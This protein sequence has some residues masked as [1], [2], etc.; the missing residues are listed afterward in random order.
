MRP[1]LLRPRYLVALALSAACL[2]AC[3]SDEE[4]FATHME[5]AEGYLAE[6]KTKE[7]LIEYRSALQIDPKNAEVNHRIADI[8]AD[9]G[10]VSEAAFFYRE[11]YRLDPE[12]VDAAMKEAQLLLFTD[13]ARTEQIIEEG[14]QR[15]PNVPIVHVARSQLALLKRDTE[16]ALTAI[17]TGIQLAPDEPGV[18]RQLGAVHQAR[19]RESRLVKKQE[20]DESVFRSAI[21]AFERADEL[22]GGNLGA[23]IERARVFASWS[24]H[25]E[26]AEQ[27]YRGVVELARSGGDDDVV[28]Y[29]ASVAGEYALR[30][31]NIPMRKW[32]LREM[33]SVD[34]SRIPNWAELA[35]LEDGEAVYAELLAKRPEDP[36]AHSYYASFLMGK[37]KNQEAITHLTQVIDA[38]HGTAALWEQ[39]LRIHLG[40]RNLPAARATYVQ[41]ADAHPDDPLTERAE[42]R[43][44]L[45]ERRRERAGQILR[46]LAGKSEAFETLRLLAFAEYANGN[47]PAAAAAI[48]RAI[49]LTDSF[50]TEAV[51]LKARIHHDAEDWILALRTLR[52][53]IGRNVVLTNNERLM[54]ARVLYETSRR[55]LGREVLELLLAEPDAP[56][57]A[58]VE[59]ARRE[60]KVRP[61]RAYQHLEKAWSRAPL[62]NDVLSELMALDIQLGKPIASLRRLNGA[63]RTGRANPKILLMRAELLARAGNYDQA[64]ADA[65]RAFE[66]APQ[67]R[68]AVDL[69]LAIYTAQGRI[70]EARRSFEEAEEAGVLHAGARLLLGRLY[71]SAGD[72]QNAERMFEKV[73]DEQPGHAGAKNDLAFLLAEEGRDL[74]RALRLAQEAQ[75]DLGSNASAADTV[76]YVFYHKGL[77]EAALQQFRYAIEL[78]QKTREGNLP[79]Y[80]YHAG[81]TLRALG[82][83]NEA[84][85]AFEKALEIDGDF[86]N[87][88]DARQQLEAARAAGPSSP[89]PS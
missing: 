47:L 6:D 30:V 52:L 11:A 10:G 67:L 83:E 82:R 23:R 37:G 1:T 45:A 84:A 76:G 49:A 18:W 86:R 12:R 87:A 48:D 14:L 16:G 41:M 19:I 68:G 8:M 17:M 71:L 21:K 25:A 9:A 40:Q 43:I 32:A 51:R 65:L 74:E 77:H 4:K 60:G 46:S 27:A 24:G 55:R 88:D 3:A 58:A 89:S 81:L 35:Q 73:L 85:Q 75:E 54:R 38:G 79:A 78:A 72:T 66:A 57:A 80:H 33:I 44:A 20:P 26:E 70:D 13:T 63:I 59:F 36:V 62:D 28:L 39:L 56:P 22:S 31:G 15:Y 34:D 5:R 64:E 2:A 29:A 69:L 7:A 61:N 42:A 53:L 50:S